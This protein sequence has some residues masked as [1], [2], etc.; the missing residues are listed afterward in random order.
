[1][2]LLSVNVSE[3]RSVVHNGQVIQ[4]SIFKEPV[5][6]RVMMRE[7]NIDGDAQADLRNHGGVHKAVYAY[8]IENY[9]FWKMELKRDDFTYGQ[10]GENLTV[11]RM[12]ED[13]AHIG[14]MFR[15]G[16][17]VVQVTQ[18]RNPCYKLGIKMG[19]AEFVRT[20]LQSCRLGIY[21][22]VLEEGEI[23]VGDAIERIKED[24][25]RMTISEIARLR[26]IDTENIEG[27]KKALR[28]Q[29]LAPAFKQDFENR[30]KKAGD[31]GQKSDQHPY[32]DRALANR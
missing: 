8:P 14:D 11:E 24:P 19:S 26:N 10:F 23:G 13:N 32:G 21:M 3:P 2:K 6:G 20:F 5:S 16:E 22:R 28:I 18:P 17:A 30:L 29:A 12:T 15:I 31:I 4:T 25:E 27:L 7:M 9:E 1:M